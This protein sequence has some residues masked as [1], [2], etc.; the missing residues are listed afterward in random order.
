MNAPRPDGDHQTISE[1][2]HPFRRY[3]WRYF[4]ITF[5]I[6]W[7]FWSTGALLGLEFTDPPM[8]ALFVLGGSGPPLAALLMAHRER[9]RAGLRDIWRRL[10]DVRR[11]KRTWY[12]LIAAAV[13]LP[14]FGMVLFDWLLWGD[15]GGLASA[16]RFLITP[17]A[18]FGALA[19]M[20]I[21]VIPEEIG[22]R[23]YG[24]D[25]LLHRYSALGA[26]LILGTFWMI[27]HLP[28]YF[29]PGTF[30]HDTVGLGTVRYWTIN[31]AIPL[32]AVLHTWIYN[33]TAR[34]IYSA[35]LFHILWNLAGEAFDPSARADLVRLIL[36][37]LLTAG[38]L[39]CWGYRGMTR[40]SATQG[41]DQSLPGSRAV[42]G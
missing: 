30:L 17:V 21:A 40:Q 41:R 38:V 1:T 5:A 33:N 26:S 12:L 11:V 39:L 4:A 10:I 32:I 19:Y 29:V 16:G 3:P 13:L 15:G 28:L 22:W 7:T 31:L 34:S 36:L 27:W 8:L 6:T 14:H 23:G 37:A 2:E 20:L 35:V 18:L 24:L 42:A 9:G 25:P